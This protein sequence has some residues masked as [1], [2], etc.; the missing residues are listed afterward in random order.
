MDG[1]DKA[2]ESPKR[3]LA[4]VMKHLQECSEEKRQQVTE[5]RKRI[6]EKSAKEL[7]ELSQFMFMPDLITAMQRSMHTEKME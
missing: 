4:G 3:P 6:Q 1:A 5:K 2:E 7:E